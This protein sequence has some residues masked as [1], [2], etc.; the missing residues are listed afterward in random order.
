MTN[1]IQDDVAG[2]SKEVEGPQL[3]TAEQNHSTEPLTSV[4]D[5]VDHQRAP[6]VAVR[7][8]VDDSELT[9]PPRSE[10]I[11]YHREPGLQPRTEPDDTVLNDRSHPP[12]DELTSDQLQQ[13]A[14]RKPR[15]KR[16]VKIKGRKAAEATT[17]A[18]DRMLNGHEDAVDWFTAVRSADIA[19]F[20]RLAE[21][22]T[23]DVNSV[24]EVSQIINLIIANSKH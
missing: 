1:S 7:E 2:P 18:T 10:V 9:S 21:S 3:K 24:D 6:A 17:D 23:V 14:S 22:G 11:A 4:A 5:H 12:Q 13:Q 8:S 20:R 16:K 19:T 15:G